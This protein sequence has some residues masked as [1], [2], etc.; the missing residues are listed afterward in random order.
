MREIQPRAIRSSTRGDEDNIVTS[1]EGLVLTVEMPSKCLLST[2]VAL[3][4]ISCISASVALI[5]NTPRIGEELVFGSAQSY[6]LTSLVADGFYEVKVSYPGYNPS[7]FTI[8]W[9]EPDVGKTMRHLANADKVMFRTDDQGKIIGGHEP[10]I[11]ISAIQEAP[12]AFPTSN[13]TVVYDIVLEELLYGAPTGI[14]KI[15]L[16]IL[17]VILGGVFLRRKYKLQ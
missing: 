14:W 4:C 16:L 8:S 3:I 17:G 1:C 5:P 6:V 13:P 2:C 11:W 9:S 7:K 12:A 10:V 15:V